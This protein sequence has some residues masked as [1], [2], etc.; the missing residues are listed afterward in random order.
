MKR[1]GTAV[2]KRQGKEKDRK[3]KD[4]EKQE[5]NHYAKNNPKRLKKAQEQKNTP[6]PAQRKKHVFILRTQTHTGKDTETP[7][8]HLYIEPTPTEPSVFV[9]QLGKSLNLP[10]ARGPN[11]RDPSSALE[12]W[13]LT[14]AGDEKNTLV[15]CFLKVSR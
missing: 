11:W 8:Q 4:Q 14:S 15:G 6:S 2:E 13:I 3:E 9:V 1:K 12:I 10:F 7:L 5:E